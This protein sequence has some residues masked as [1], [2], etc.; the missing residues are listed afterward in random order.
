MNNLLNERVGDLIAHHEA[1]GVL[2]PGTGIAVSVVE[3]GSVRFT[4][5]YGWRERDHCLPV[6]PQTL[7]EIGSLTKAFTAT[8]LV[9]A[10]DRGRSIS[11][12]RLTHRPG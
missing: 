8:S 3:G 6:T 7:F 2:A 12:A 4:G 11:T 1:A 5:T 10:S 9:M